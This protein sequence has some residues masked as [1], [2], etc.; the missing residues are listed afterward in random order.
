MEKHPLPFLFVYLGVVVMQ[1]KRKFNYMNLLLILVFAVGLGILLYPN[2]SNFFNE[3]NSSKAIEEYDETIAEMN[4]EE[5]RKIM[6]SAVNYNSE[7]S[8]DPVGRFAKMTAQQKERY[9]KELNVDG[10]G[11]MCYLKIDKLGV[12]LPVFHGTTEDVLQKY[13]GHIEGTS[14]PTGGPGTHAGL[15]GHRGLPS[16]VLFTN[17]DQ[18]E[19]G[20]Q[21]SV[22]VLGEEHVY[23]I[24]QILT[25]LP[26]D[27]SPLAIDPNEDYITLVTCTPYGVNT[28][29]LMVRGKRVPPEE[30]E[31]IIENGDNTQKVKWTREKIV[32]I[33]AITMTALFAGFMLPIWLFPVVPK[34]KIYLRPWDD[35]IEKTISSA[36]KIS[37]EATRAN[38]VMEPLAK[39]SDWLATLRRWD[40]TMVYKEVL[41]DEDSTRPWN[42]YEY[43]EDEQ[44]MSKEEKK[45]KRQWD[46]DVL[47]KV[48]QDWQ[49][50]D[51]KFHREAI[52]YRDVDEI[53]ERGSVEDKDT[54]VE[55]SI[56]YEKELGHQKLAFHKRDKENV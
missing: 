34:R 8:T 56:E 21:F 31:E 12:N 24:D 27:M 48:D 2:I 44:A 3:K 16:A 28:H 11:M 26:D 10:S 7:I 5:R 22:I 4:A 52:R 41:S 29:R 47:E 20:D 53:Y 35:N 51:R 40:E 19:V 39:A 1:E 37:E 9:F 25:V 36:I 54:R 55:E 45:A 42:E 32:N 6:E 14:L 17:L 13:V 23:Q 30:E 49:P 15:S 50:I 38:W 33:I 18:L 46:D 43:S